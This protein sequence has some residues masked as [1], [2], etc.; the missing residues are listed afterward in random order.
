ML[1]VDNLRYGPWRFSDEEMRRFTADATDLRDLAA[2]EALVA[3]FRPDAIIH[4]AAIHFIPE[5]ERLPDE[6]VSI[7]VTATISLARACP[8]GCR[9]VLASTAAV[10]A[11][12]DKAHS[13][14]FSAIGPMDVY[15]LSKLSA[16]QYV[17]YYSALRGFPAAVIRL[18]NVVGPGETNPHV[19]PEIIRQLRHGAPNL[20]LGNITPKRDYI[21]VRDAA[22]GFIAAALNAGPEAARGVQIANLG[23]GAS[24]SVAEMVERMSRVIGEKI[25]VTIDPAKVRASDRP[26]LLAD[27]RRMKH[28]FGWAPQHDIDSALEITWRDPDMLEVLN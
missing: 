6:A 10:Y 1:A 12:S 24:Y 23:T 25:E 11:P 19:L 21:Y 26:Q 22:R 17:A 16:E 7:N 2:T 9:F 20:S 13:E 18:F 3:G 27:N 8:V 4:L 28:L 15:G 5:C 14:D